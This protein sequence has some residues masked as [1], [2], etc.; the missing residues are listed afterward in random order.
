VA[1]PGRASRT[2][3]A[4]GLPSV[5]LALGVLFSVTFTCLLLPLILRETALSSATE[6]RA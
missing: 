2:G 4:W 6:L 1:P 5:L 3:D